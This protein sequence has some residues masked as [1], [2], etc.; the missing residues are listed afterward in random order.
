MIK[1][2]DK[3]NELDKNLNDFET[4][5]VSNPTREDMLAQVFDTLRKA[6]LHDLGIKS[7]GYVKILESYCTYLEDTIKFKI[8]SREKQIKTFNYI[9][10]GLLLLSGVV[11]IL[12]F[13]YGFKNKEFGVE[14]ALVLVTSLISLIGTIIIIP[15]KIIEFVFNKDDEKNIA[16]I[17][18]NILDY[19]KQ[20]RSLYN[21]M[22]SNIVAED[23]DSETNN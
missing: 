16:E 2:K 1:K 14:I 10:K 12:T 17:I 21:D 22:Q 6:D 23:T 20:L 8:I 15:T 18:K 5:M 4:R 7:E 3:E 19:D 13:I 11:I 9:L